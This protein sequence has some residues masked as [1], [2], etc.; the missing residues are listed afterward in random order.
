MRKRRDIHMF[1]CLAAGLAYPGLA[2]A[3][4]R[5]VDG[6]HWTGV[7]RIVA[8]GDLHGDYDQYM[9]VL[10]MAGLVNSRGEWAGGET[11]L[12]QTGDVPDRGP[13][14]R[15]IIDHLMDLKKQA[16]R[17]GGRVHTLIGNHEAMNVYGDLRFVTPGEFEAFRARDSKRYQDLQIEHH[18]RTMRARDPEAFEALDL[19]SIRE[20]LGEQ[21]PPGWVE[22]RQAWSAG[23]EY[24]DYVLGNPVAVKVNDTLFLHAGLSA[25][26]CQA[27]LAELSERVHAGLADFDYRN[28]GI[29]EDELGP[30]WYRGLATDDETERGPMVDAVL[31]RY[32]ASRM[33]VGHTPT[34]GVVWPRFGGRVILNDT[35]IADYY[36]GHAAFL[37]ISP[38]GAVAHYPGG[39]LPLPGD[40]AD[41][42]DYLAGVVELEPANAPLRSRLEKMRIAIGRTPKTD[43]AADAGQ[44]EGWLSPDNCR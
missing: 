34:Q 12:V 9:K 7:D 21:Y 42:L 18:L 17:D 27:S 38:A 20:A 39:A 31:A 32:G 30:L 1:I 11:H 28:P 2:V 24:G 4:V 33:V 29:V 41:R 15:R 3:E 14:S 6:Y 22:H 35:G 5:Q 37:E 44:R 23:G 43:V 40:G 13:D 36:G 19:E 26:Y 8:I 25:R 16:E 10:E